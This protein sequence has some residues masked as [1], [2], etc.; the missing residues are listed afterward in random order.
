MQD[1]VSK[2]TRPQTICEFAIVE[3]L[4]VAYPASEADA[5]IEVSQKGDE[6]RRKKELVPP[7][8]T[9]QMDRSIYAKGFPE[10]D[11]TDDDDKSEGKSDSVQKGLKLQKDL[12]EFFTGLGVGK[13]NA[14][15]MRRDE[16]KK[17]KGSVF[18]E[19]ATLESAKAVVDMEDKPTFPGQS[20]AIQVMFK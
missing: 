19:F 7:G 8:Q 4:K 13:V 15:R 14:V 18:V 3:A 10:G 9:G 6:V 2:S 5:L 1:I 17:F 11:S 16:Q 12:E 20:E